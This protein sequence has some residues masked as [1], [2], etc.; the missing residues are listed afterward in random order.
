MRVEK[1]M[2]AS[3]LFFVASLVWFRQSSSACVEHVRTPRE[4]RLGR[5]WSQGY[6]LELQHLPHH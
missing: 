3:S 1:S 6:G 5:H 2:E 4:L